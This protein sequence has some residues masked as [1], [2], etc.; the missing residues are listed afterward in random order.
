MFEKILIANRGEIALRVIRACREM[1]IASVAVYCDADARAPHVREADEAVLHRARAVERVLPEGR[2]HHRRGA[3]GRRR[4]DSSGLRIPLRARMV[5]ARGSR[6]GTRLHRTAGRG[7]RGDGKQDGGAPAGDRRR[8]VPVVPGT[9]SAL[10]D[11]DEARA[12][13]RA[14]RLPGAAQGG[15]RRW[16]Q[17]NAR[18]AR[19]RASSPRA[20]DVRAARGEAMRSATTRCTSRSTSSARGTSR[21]RCSAISTGPCCRSASANA[22]C[23]AGIRR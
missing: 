18:R 6:R 13:R 20:L 16:R 14:I 11:A 1:G 4:G 19:A 21:S 3:A 2:P 17:G 22:R 23:S 8:N 12:G 10:R 9:T 7:D 15:G 5:R